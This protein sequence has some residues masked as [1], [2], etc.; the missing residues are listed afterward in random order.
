MYWVGLFAAV[1]LLM[2]A[3]QM[4]LRPQKFVGTGR[5]DATEPRTV[6]AF[7]WGTLALGLALLGLSLISLVEGK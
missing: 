4:L 2:N 1:G 5:F 3:G 6:K 7:G